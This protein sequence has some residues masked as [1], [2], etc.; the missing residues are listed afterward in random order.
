S[1]E[2]LQEFIVQT[3]LYDASNGRNAGGNVEAVT[4]SGGNDFHGNVFYFLRNK[5]LNANE[6]FIKARGLERPILTRNQFGGTLGG[7]IVRDKAFFFFSYQGTR[8]RNGLSLSNS[9]T[10][11]S[12]PAGLS[13]GNRTRSEEHTSELQSPYDLVCRLL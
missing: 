7:R 1:T 11:P 9:L 8:E 2:S 6:P 4:R 12:V 13:D 5:A 10:F 3:S